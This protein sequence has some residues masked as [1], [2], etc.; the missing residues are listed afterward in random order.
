MK[1]KDTRKDDEMEYCEESLYYLLRYGHKNSSGPWDDCNCDRCKN[2]FCLPDED[3]AGLIVR[4]L[5][6]YYENQTA[7]ISDQRRKALS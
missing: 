2:G 6:E 3:E 1:L 5:K 7:Q 4:L